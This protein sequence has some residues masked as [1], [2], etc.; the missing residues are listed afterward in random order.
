MASHVLSRGTTFARS[1]GALLLREM[2]STY[3]RSPGGYAWA[4]LE[5]VA[6]VAI[7]T[8]VLTFITRTPPLG[9]NFP[10]FF[11]TGI[12]VFGVYASTS[13]KIGGAIRYSKPLLAYPTV[14]YIDAILARL[15]LNTLT[16]ITVCTIVLTGVIVVFDLRVFI[17]FGAVVG[18]FGLAVLF[19][20]GVGLVNCFLMSMF[21]L[22]QFI[23]AVVNRPMFI[24]SGIFYLIDA[25]P[26]QVRWWLMLNPV[27]HT[28]SEMRAGFYVTYDAVYVSYLYVF[29][30]S[31]VLMAVGMLLLHRYHRI[32]LDEGG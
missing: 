20:T 10:L 21:P 1:V 25:L 27:A 19:G 4:I 12:L 9:T 24:I 2:S 29:L 5:P 32:L 3:G 17:D 14:T 31:L 23:W 8:V 15:I 13:A 30:V 16:Q 22:W 26:E 28:I 7:L 18:A 6:G 11:A